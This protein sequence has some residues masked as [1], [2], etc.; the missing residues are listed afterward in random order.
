MPSRGHLFYSSKKVYSCPEMESFIKERNCKRI[1]LLTSIGGV[2]EE[3]N[4]GIDCCDVCGGD[5]VS[6]RLKILSRSVVS[7]RKKRSRRLIDKKYLEGRLKEIRETVLSEHP[8]FRMLGVNFLCPDST[9]MKVCE[10]ATFAMDHK[11]FTVNLRSELRDQFIS[12]ALSSSSLI[13]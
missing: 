4:R 5:P 8:A 12:A 6:S 7:R 1:T 13:S 3:T 10:E 9:I 11:D 2:V